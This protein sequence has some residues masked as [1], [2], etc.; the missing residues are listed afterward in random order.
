MPST[1]LVSGKKVVRNT[2]SSRQ[3]SEVATKIPAPGVQILYN[4]PWVWVVPVNMTDAA[5]WWDYDTW[6]SV[7]L[8]R[9]IILGE[10]GLIKE[11]LKGSWPFLKRRSMRVQSTWDW[12]CERTDGEKHISKNVI[13]TSRIWGLCLLKAAKFQGP[14]SCNHKEINSANNLRWFG[15]GLG[16]VSRWV[17]IHLMPRFQPGENPTVLCQ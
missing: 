8:K 1:V 2:S 17:H 12:V 14:Q 9:E 15:N 7:L 10:H 6:H 5:S 11:V 4:L 13:V 3:D 16:W